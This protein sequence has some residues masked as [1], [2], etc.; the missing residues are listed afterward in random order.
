MQQRNLPDGVVTSALN[1]ISRNNHGVVRLGQNVCLARGRMH[2][3]QGDSAE[4]FA[5]IAGVVLDGPIFWCGLRDDVE[6]LSPL[7]AQPFFG[8]ARLVMAEGVSRLEV[9][10]AGEQA[11]RTEG[12][13]CVVIE[14]QSGPD[15]KESRRLQ[16]AAEESG[17]LG[18]VLIKGRTQTSAA[19][20]RWHCDALDDKSAIWRWCCTK[21]RK[22]ETGTWDVTW[23]GYGNGPDFI[24]MA[25][26]TAA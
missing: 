11:L 13:S 23:R 14:L 8:P 25:A 1:T 3:I 9:L 21:N 4:A 12:I 16:V 24:H 18:L 22:G 17:A 19:E 7:G 20:T 5:M 26:A 2:E 15:L 10:W 6:S